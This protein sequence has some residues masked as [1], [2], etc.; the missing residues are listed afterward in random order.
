MIVKGGGEALLVH[1]A[2]SIMR[3]KQLRRFARFVAGV[4][5]IEISDD[6]DAATVLRDATG[7]GR[8]SCEIP[9]LPS[10]LEGVNTVL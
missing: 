9:P 10:T 1:S 4:F 7:G 2:N 8:V 3:N 6:D 5:R